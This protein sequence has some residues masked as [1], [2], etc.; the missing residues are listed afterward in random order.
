MAT[1]RTPPSCARLRQQK[2]CH[3]GLPRGARSSAG[4]LTLGTSHAAQ[5]PHGVAEG[6]EPTPATGC[7]PP[8]Q[9]SWSPSAAGVGTPQVRGRPPSGSQEKTPGV[10]P[11]RRPLGRW[12]LCSA[13]VRHP[14]WPSWR[15]CR[16]CPPRRHAC[17]LGST[18]PTGA[19]PSACRKLPDGRV[20]P[21]RVP[22]HAGARQPGPDGDGLC[23]V[24][25]P[26][27]R[28]QWQE[29]AG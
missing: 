12:W 3:T 19:A 23:P 4:V 7:P 20:V 25:G 22:R 10:L 18:Q 13:K 8:S 27:P 16:M 14:S 28:G 24:S 2:R 29:D 15:A 9:W 26:P 17:T 21:R 6:L 5:A 11:S 1:G